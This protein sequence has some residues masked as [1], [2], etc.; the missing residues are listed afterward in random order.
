MYQI[1]M[2]WHTTTKSVNHT[3]QVSHL[4]TRAKQ[5]FNTLGVKW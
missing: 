4:P 5:S 2:S 1:H 3:V